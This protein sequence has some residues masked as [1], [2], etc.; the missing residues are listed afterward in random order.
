MEVLET[1]D[2][3]ILESQESSRKFCI[4]RLKSIIVAIIELEKVCYFKNTSNNILG[5]L[6]TIKSIDIIT[7]GTDFFWASLH[8]I[9]S[10][11]GHDDKRLV[12]IIYCCFLQNAFDSF[13]EILPDGSFVEF[14]NGGDDEIPFIKL[15]LSLR[16]YFEKNI[17]L[18]KLSNSLLSFTI[19]NNFAGYTEKLIFISLE[20]IPTA[21]ML[22]EKITPDNIVLLLQRHQNLYENVYYNECT[23]NLFLASLLYDKV[24]RALNIIKKTNITYFNGLNLNLKYIVAIGNDIEGNSPSFASALLKQTIFLSVDL[25]MKPLLFLVETIIHEYSHCELHLVQDTMLLTLNEN[26]VFEYYSPWRVDPR[27]L[28]GLIHGIYVSYKVVLFNL[29][30]LCTSNN[31]NSDQNFVTHRT[32][33]LIHQILIAIKQVRKDDLTD[34]SLYLS[35][36]VRVNTLKIAAILKFDLSKYPDEIKVHQANWLKENSLLTIKIVA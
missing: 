22:R 20:N 6:L 28:L 18:T 12:E 25:M 10:I 4:L 36:S 19:D 2:Q 14:Y 11:L 13:F 23:S 31:N 33:I 29:S 32:E 21:F 9:N 24:E 3:I 35:E 15:K 30:F 5:H 17:V 16:S 1:F 7:N 26:N 8:R 34:L 27:P